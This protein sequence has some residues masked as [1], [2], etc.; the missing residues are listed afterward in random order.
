M[1]QR[2]GKKFVS[3]GKKVALVINNRLDHPQIENVKSIKMFSLPTNTTSQT[4]P[5]DQCVIRSLKAQYRKNVVHKIIQSVERKKILSN[6]FLLL[7][8]QM[9]LAAQ[10]APMAK[11]I[12]NCFRKFKIS[13]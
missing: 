9:L 11:A 7:E 1:G 12:V 5:M 4:Q 10:D 3:E 6:F 13:S 2:D 8:M